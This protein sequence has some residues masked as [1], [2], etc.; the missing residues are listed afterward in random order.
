MVVMLGVGFVP[1][2][3]QGV[4][5]VV[6]GR[7]DEARPGSPAPSIATI[8]WAPPWHP[9]PT[10][11]PLAPVVVE[12]ISPS[13]CET[14]ELCPR[15]WAFPKLDRVEKET[16]DAAD[17]GHATHA[18]HDRYFKYGT[19]YDLTTRA[20]ELALATSG[21][22][23]DRETFG[24]RVEQELRFRH[25]SVPG[26]WF[27]G[28]IDLNWAQ[29]ETLHGGADGHAGVWRLRRIV[30]DHKTT[31][32][33][34]YMKLTREALLG[35]PQAPVYGMMFFIGEGQERVPPAPG[36]QGRG[37]WRDWAIDAATDPLELRWNYVLTSS[38]AAAIPTEKSWHEVTKYEI[39]EAFERHVVPHARKLL[40]IV[41]QAN[42]V[43]STGHPFGAA[44]VEA[45]TGDACF[46]FGGCPFRSR[47]NIA[48]IEGVRAMTAGASDFLTRVGVTAPGQAPGQPWSPPG[49][50]QPGPP[51]GA[52]P[53]PQGAWAPPGQAAQPGPPPGAQYGGNS[54]QQG[55]P[56][57]AWQ[58]PQPGSALAQAQAGYPPNG[59]PNGGMPASAP[60]TV[61]YG[62]QVNPPEQGQQMQPPPPDAAAQEKARIKA[63][64]AEAK[65]LAAEL[66][67]ANAATQAAPSTVNVSGPSFE[68]LAMA[69]CLSTL[70]PVMIMNGASAENVVDMAYELTHRAIAKGVR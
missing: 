55:A 47:C 54:A 27:G 53:P 37:T 34:R 17:L 57:Q 56:Q 35:H 21:M 12:Y 39:D 69:R 10:H 45:K 8:P 29:Q 38:K 48:P 36:E 58:N 46:A 32:Q 16:T 63:E 5:N 49:Q 15:K 65:R 1:P 62:T 20:G 24:L 26:V 61:G 44:D 64:K 30:L 25:P 6:P 66:A 52:P 22:L 42:A 67:A 50:A 60:G 11:D 9:K 51:Q 23:P 2:P 3:V 28:K 41:D 7:A 70:A 13:A 59:S 31:G 68:A 40:Q 18:Q 19:P 4:G 43:R 14:I 33:R